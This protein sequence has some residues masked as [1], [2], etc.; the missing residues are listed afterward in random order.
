MRGASPDQPSGNTP[1][2]SFRMLNRSCGTCFMPEGQEMCVPYDSDWLEVSRLL[3]STELGVY[4]N[5]CR[6]FLQVDVE[7][8][9]ASLSAVALCSSPNHLI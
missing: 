7:N 5:F 1:F 2:V 3:S 4:T 8:V 9:A 6:Y